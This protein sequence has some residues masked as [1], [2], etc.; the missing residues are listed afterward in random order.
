[1][2]LDRFLRSGSIALLTI[3][4]LA[5]NAAPGD[6][7]ERNSRAVPSPQTCEQFR[8]Q[9]NQLMNS[10]IGDDKA[11]VTKGGVNMKEKELLALM[12]A[13]EKHRYRELTAKLQQCE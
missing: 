11:S 13:T 6:Q 5:A 7:R 1:M 2:N 9:R 10:A 3:L 12:N 8:Q 4:P